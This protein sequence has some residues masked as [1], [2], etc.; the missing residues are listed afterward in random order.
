MLVDDKFWPNILLFKKQ[1]V[2]IT[3]LLFPQSLHYF[4]PIV[5]FLLKVVCKT[6]TALASDLLIDN[7]ILPRENSENADVL[8]VITI[9]CLQLVNKPSNKTHVSD[10]L[11]RLCTVRGNHVSSTSSHP[12]VKFCELHIKHVL[13]ES[14]SILSVALLCLDHP[15]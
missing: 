12:V 14:G 9:N 13:Q 11:C 1:N 5:K 8:S 10:P 3:R 7:M 2:L 6:M 15:S 4:P